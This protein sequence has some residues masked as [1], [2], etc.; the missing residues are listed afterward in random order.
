MNASAL[1]GRLPKRSPESSANAIILVV[2][3]MMAKYAVV[4]ITAS[5]CAAPVSVMTTGLMLT[6]TARSQTPTALTP[7]PTKSATEG[8][9]VIVVSVFVSL[10]VTN[11]ILDSTA[12]TVQPVSLSARPTK[13]VFS[14]VSIRADLWMRRRAI[15]A[16]LTQ[17][18]HPSSTSRKGNSSAFSLMT[19]TANSN[20][21]TNTTKTRI[22]FM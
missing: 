4:P 2:I 13:S 21:N 16:I 18:A 9:S 10:R 5:V 1:N 14:V 17:S 19:T 3:D 12:R 8:D 11:N 22:S 20:S 7:E 6:V 15:D